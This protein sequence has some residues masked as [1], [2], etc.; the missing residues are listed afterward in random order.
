MKLKDTLI[1]EFHALGI[2]G[3]EVKELH[4]LNGFFVNL[5]YP[6]ANGQSVK[7]LEDKKIYL[8]NQIERPGSDRC[9]GIVA[10]ESYLLVCEYG[11]NGTDPEIII[12]KKRNTV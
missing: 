9:Y 3:L 7:L 10:D 2:E 8:G 11:C 4:L 5:E 1:S 6:L 12:Y